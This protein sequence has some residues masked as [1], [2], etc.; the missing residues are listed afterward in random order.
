MGHFEIEFDEAKRALTL[1]KRG[2]DFLDTPSLFAGSHLQLLDDRLDYGEPRYNSFGMLEDRN[3]VV[4]WTP[5]G[6]KR[7]I[8]A[9][10]HY[11]DEELENRRRTLD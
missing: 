5:R 1:E 10:R 4:T 7:R 2:L 11:H 6:N 9:M 8:I 3:V